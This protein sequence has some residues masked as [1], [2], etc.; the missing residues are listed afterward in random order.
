MEEGKAE[1]GQDK[2]KRR[3]DEKARERLK[4]KG[5]RKERGLG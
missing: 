3:M 5:N 1:A 2:R 4:K